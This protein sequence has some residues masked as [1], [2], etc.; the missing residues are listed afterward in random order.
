MFK[1]EDPPMYVEDYAGAI[2]EVHRVLRA[3]GEL[4]MSITHPCFSAP[5]SEWVRDDSTGGLQVRSRPRSV[6]EP[7]GRNL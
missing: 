5:V 4:V 7:F 3:G 1:R 6:A 2:R